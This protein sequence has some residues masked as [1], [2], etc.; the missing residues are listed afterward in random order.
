MSYSESMKLSNP[1]LIKEYQTVREQWVK[2]YKRKMLADSKGYVVSGLEGMHC[3]CHCIF[4]A[5][6]VIFELMLD[7]SRRTEQS[8]QYQRRDIVSETIESILDTTQFSL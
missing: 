8:A 4:Q 2:V 1:E 3:T 7:N 5:D 6:K